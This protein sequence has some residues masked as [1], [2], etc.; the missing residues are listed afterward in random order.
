M[1]L[2]I[3]AFVATILFFLWR[4]SKKWFPTHKESNM[5]DSADRVVWCN[6]FTM[7]LN[8]ISVTI[9]NPDPEELLSSFLRNKMELTG[10][11]L[12]C[13]EGGCGACTVVLT[14][15]ANFSSS[16]VLSVNACLRPLCCNDGLSVTTVECI[17]STCGGL[18][19]EHQSFVRNHGTHCCY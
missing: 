3:V 17:G 1:F 15:P 11:K 10:T 5:I 13:E 9:T 8:G 2:V 18:S 6:E 14:R 4:K 16:E 12:G 7:Y 19:E